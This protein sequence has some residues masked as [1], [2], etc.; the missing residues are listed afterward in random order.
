[1]QKLTCNPPT[2]QKAPVPADGPSG[3]KPSDLAGKPG[4]IQ[5]KVK[6]HV[7]WG[8]RGFLVTAGE[9]VVFIPKAALTPWQVKG[10]RRAQARGQ[11]VYAKGTFNESGFLEPS[12][13]RFSY[14]H[15]PDTPR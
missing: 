7:G 14:S 11:D 8:P 10:M 4:E 15:I 13:L 5:G 1:M 3:R 6:E 9:K 2:S 12:V